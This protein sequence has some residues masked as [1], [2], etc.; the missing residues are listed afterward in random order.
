[1]NV[2]WLPEKGV[3][4]PN[5]ELADAEG[6]LAIGGDLS[7]E[8]LISAYACGI[9]PWY[10]DDSPILWWSPDPR[11]V[12]YPDA[13]HIPRSLRRV[14][15]ARRF[16]IT[17]DTAFD[18]VIQECACS[19]RPDQNGTWIVSDMIKAYSELHMHGLA[20]S[21]EAWLDGRLV[22]G[23]YGVSLGKIFFGESMFYKAPDASKVALVWLVSLLRAAGFAM[24]DCQ[25]VTHNL[26]RF[27]GQEVRRSEF[28]EQLKK[29]LREP[30][31]QGLWTIPEDFFPLSVR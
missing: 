30:T 9:F 2:F 24:L 31:V 27:G 17:M 26:R 21:V 3:D 28:L 18:T 1:M 20:H 13:L 15:N 19:S 14:I 22:G 7:V 12:L 10:N 23:M 5:P 11:F 8:R 25:Q 29:A 6:L 4:F 16:H